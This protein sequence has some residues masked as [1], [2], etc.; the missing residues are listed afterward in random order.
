[1]EEYNNNVMVFK[2]LLANLEE[3]LFPRMKARDRFLKKEEPS[4]VTKAEVLLNDEMREYIQLLRNYVIVLEEANKQLINL[5]GID[6]QNKYILALEKELLHEFRTR[7]NI[8]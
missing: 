8:S 4:P 6:H 5:S 3:S 7:H 1:M 2:R